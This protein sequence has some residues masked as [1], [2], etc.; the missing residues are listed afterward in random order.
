[1]TFL[2]TM[3]GGGLALLFCYLSFLSS[4]SGQALPSDVE[5]IKDDIVKA[6]LL[7]QE[8]YKQATEQVSQGNSLLGQRE[9]QKAIDAYLAAIKSLEKCS[10]S[11]ATILQKIEG[12]KKQIALSYEYWSRDLYI[13]A[14]EKLKIQNLAEAIKLCDL[15]SAV[16]P[17]SKKQ[18]DELIAKYK[19]AQKA[20]IYRQA[21]K[22]E[23]V[24]PDMEQRRFNIDVLMRQAKAYYDANK[25]E[26]ARSKCEEVLV[27]DPYNSDAINYV[28]K[29]NLTLK[30]RAT[31]RLA[32]THAER[33]AEAEWKGVSPLIPK[34]YSSDM[35]ASASPIKKEVAEDLI[36]K[37]LKNIIID[38]IEFEEVTIPTVVK[39]LKM[40]SKQIDPEKVGVNIFL[41]IPPLRQSSGRCPGC[42]P[43]WRYRRA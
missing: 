30:Q 40:R 37:K 42:R 41:R 11:R 15:A 21:T 22:E 38:H 33:V 13:Q 29:I 7:R 27:I 8:S 35:S 4:A 28:Y 20:L 2:R 16:Y 1:M 10:A 26:K 14:E 12:V 5:N 25:L 19:A 36:H 31:Q 24:I 18:N 39:Y 3:S 34:T 6:D 17:P 32:S 23:T 43:D 9:Y